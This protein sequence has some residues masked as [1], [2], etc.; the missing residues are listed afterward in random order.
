MSAATKAKISAAKKGKKHTQQTKE[1]IS[2]AIKARWAEIPVD[3]KG[4]IM[5]NV[6]RWRK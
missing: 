3:P 4:E 2:A 1:K 6:C 5:L